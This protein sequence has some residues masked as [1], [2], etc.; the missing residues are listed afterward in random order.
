MTGPTLRLSRV[1]HQHQESGR[2]RGW[3]SKSLLAYASNVVQSV[4][5]HVLAVPGWQPSIVLTILFIPW[6]SYLTASC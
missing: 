4:L 1:V 6:F 3:A 2:S 5:K